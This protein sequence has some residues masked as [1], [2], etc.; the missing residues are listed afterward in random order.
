M[1]FFYFRYSKFGG[2]TFSF[3]SQIPNY[4]FAIFISAKAFWGEVIIL[5]TIKINKSK[6][7]AGSGW[8]WILASYQYLKQ[9]PTLKIQKLA[10]TAAEFRMLLVT[11]ISLIPKIKIKNSAAPKAGF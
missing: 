8:I 10:A 1:L 2:G 5:F 7:V 6:M 9:I 4:N 3:F 11:M